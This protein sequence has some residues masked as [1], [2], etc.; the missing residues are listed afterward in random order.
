MPSPTDPT[1]PREYAVLLPLV[2]YRQVECVLL[3]RRSD[4]LNSH[5]GEVSL[6]GGGREV[7]DESLLATALRETHEEIGI[8]SEQV[9]VIGELDRVLTRQGR[10]VKP[11]V[12]RIESPFAPRLN[13]AEVTELI[14][15]PVEILLED[16]FQERQRFRMPSGR[17]VT[18]HTFEHEGHE[19]WGLTAK[20]LRDWIRS[21]RP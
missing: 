7:Q 15:L 19:I 10:P 6:P 12:G 3:T 9:E 5:G 16:P 18:L 1:T 11:F 20:I 4:S 8:R 13:P 21:C 14:Y 17:V 2:E